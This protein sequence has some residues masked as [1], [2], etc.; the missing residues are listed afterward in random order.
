MDYSQ[1]LDVWSKNW[2]GRGD[3]N[4]HAFWAPP[5]QDGVSANFT[6][7]ARIT[8][9]GKSVFQ[10]VEGRVK[11]SKDKSSLEDEKLHKL[12]PLS[13]T[14]QRYPEPQLLSSPTRCDSNY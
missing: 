12:G 1:T 6:T 13:L 10:Q 5:P 9:T 7:S 2:C 14:W 8:R 3:L 11:Y 4:P